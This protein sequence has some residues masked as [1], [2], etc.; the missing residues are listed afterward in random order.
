MGKR[1]HGKKGSG[2]F[3]ST[4]QCVNA[5]RARVLLR[6]EAGGAGAGLKTIPGSA[7]G[8]AITLKDYLSD[9]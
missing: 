5:K 1:G 8:S 2:S 4:S 7:V 9:I 3:G 6:A